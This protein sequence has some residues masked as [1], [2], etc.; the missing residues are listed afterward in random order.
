LRQAAVA[1]E[2]DPARI[3]HTLA[4]FG[5]R[6][7]WERSKIASWLGISPDR[8]AALALEPRA[9]H[10]CPGKSSDLQDLANQYGIAPDRLAAVLAE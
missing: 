8:Y 4:S 2:R 1:A 10:G 9:I 6:R 3:G 7:N 5:R